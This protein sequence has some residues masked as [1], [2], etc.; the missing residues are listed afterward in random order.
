M[1]VNVVSQYRGGPRTVEARTSTVP[2]LVIHRTYGPWQARPE[3]GALSRWTVTHAASG[4]SVGRGETLAAV[5]RAVRSID[6]MLDRPAWEMLTAD[7]LRAIADRWHGRN[8]G[9]NIQSAAGF[10]R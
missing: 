8:Y 2:G 6:I 10:V 4:L 5:D 3:R 7:E 9:R 1:N